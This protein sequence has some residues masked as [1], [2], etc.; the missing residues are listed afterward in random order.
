[1]YIIFTPI[2]AAFWEEKYIFIDI[3]I[4]H[5]SKNAYFIKVVRIAGKIKTTF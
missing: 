3:E 4:I 5:F 1:M 2:V